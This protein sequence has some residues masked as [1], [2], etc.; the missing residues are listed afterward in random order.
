MTDWQAEGRDAY[1]ARIQELRDERDQYLED[2]SPV[3]KQIAGVFD[4]DPLEMDTD[5]IVRRPFVPVE[6]RT[7]SPSWRMPK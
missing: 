7:A 3:G 1:W 2:R 4:V 6:A 5:P